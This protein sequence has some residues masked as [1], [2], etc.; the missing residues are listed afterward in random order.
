MNAHGQISLSAPILPLDL[1]FPTATR[2]PAAALARLRRRFELSAAR[3]RVE[4]DLRRPAPA[5][6]RLGDALV[7]YAALPDRHRLLGL[8]ETQPSRPVVVHF[9]DLHGG[10]LHGI[11]GSGN[12]V[13]GDLARLQRLDQ[14]H[15]V[16]IECTVDLER[17][18]E[19][20]LAAARRLAEGGLHVR[21][22]LR[23]PE[24]GI[25]DGERLERWFA[26]AHAAG[27]G[28]VRAATG[29]VPG[30]D[31]PGADAPGADRWRTE[32]ESRRLAW[33]FPRPTPWRG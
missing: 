6:V 29:S 32:L 14:H 2:A 22:L 31:A 16:E 7:P 30:A 26:A 10:D 11:D 17:T 19:A 27:I 25:V 28:D 18:V 23:R 4:A 9:G 21:L 20:G 15:A 1:P 13:V 3:R 12:S 8:L 24:C 33:G 5:P